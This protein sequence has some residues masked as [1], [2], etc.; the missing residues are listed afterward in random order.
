MIGILCYPQSLE[1]LNILGNAVHILPLR[2]KGL[3]YPFQYGVMSFFSV[4]DR[5]PIREFVKNKSGIYCWVNLLNGKC[6]V[7]KAGSLYLRLSNYFQAAYIERTLSSSAISRAIAQYGIESFA[8]TILELEPQDLAQAEQHWIDV[9]QP[10]YNSITN[11]L[12]PYNSSTRKLDRF[13][14]NNSFF[15]R[16]HTDETKALLRAS[17]LS[18]ATPNR[19]GFEVTI[20]DTLL[21]TSSS[22][23]SIRKAVDAMGWNQ[24]N[25]MRHLR[26][27][28]TKLYL[29]RYLLDVKRS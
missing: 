10:D 15:G 25:V 12:V 21:N 8:L 19:P 23:S 26:T 2:R 9:L 7:G 28:A 5:N 29:K 17:A 14:S 22:Y 18:R 13:G 4:M 20:H 24:P 1:Y 16:K 27:N 6:Y 11:V 3:S